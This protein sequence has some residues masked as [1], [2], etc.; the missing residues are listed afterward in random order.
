[1]STG[2]CGAD[3]GGCLPSSGVAPRGLRDGL[4]IDQGSPQ[5]APLQPG[6][7]QDGVGQVGVAQIG[8]SQVSVGQVGLGELDLAEAGPD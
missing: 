6:A 4:L 7:V 1:M 8:L 5:I 3:D 2:L